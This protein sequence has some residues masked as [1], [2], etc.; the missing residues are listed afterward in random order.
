VVSFC[1][2]D[3]KTGEILLID[4]EEVVEIVLSVVGDSVVISVVIPG[5]FS[6]TYTTKDSSFVVE[7]SSDKIGFSTNTVLLF[8][9][10][11]AIICED[12]VVE[13]SEDRNEEI[14]TEVGDEDI[15]FKVV[16]VVDS[17]V[18][19]RNSS[20]SSVVGLVLCNVVVAEL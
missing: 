5:L 15:G 14:G 19:N 6:S 18:S 3:S 9:I 2:V 7:V 10:E 4:N 20:F 1:K 13:I 8:D 17:V 16:E 11:F 12:I